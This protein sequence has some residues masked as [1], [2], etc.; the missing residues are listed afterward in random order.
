MR[1]VATI[2]PMRTALVGD[3]AAATSGQLTKTSEE[4][5]NSRRLTPSPR[6]WA[7]KRRAE[8][9]GAFRHV[10][11]ESAE[12]AFRFSALRHYPQLA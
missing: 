1:S 7:N 6:F 3:C 9:H 11:G 10:A 12:C 8:K 4:T 2:Q 5:M